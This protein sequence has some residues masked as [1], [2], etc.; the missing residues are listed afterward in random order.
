M[1]SISMETFGAS[2][3]TP[4][5]VSME[6]VR[7]ADVLLGLIGLRYGHVPTGYAK[8]VTEM[9]YEA[10]CAANKIVLMY[11]PASAF[12]QRAASADADLA[13]SLNFIT[14]IQRESHT[15]GAYQEQHDLPGI[16]AADLHRVMTGGASGIIAYRKG[17]REL[18]AANYP[19]A[20]YD[21]GW[22]V[23]LLPDDG[24]PAF[25]L[26]LAT[27]QGLRP[28]Q[29]TL[30]TVRRVQGLL[31][32]SA[33]LSPCRAVYALWGAIELDYFVNNGFGASHAARAKDLWL[34]ALA[35]ADDPYN[36]KLISWLQ[37][38]LTDDYLTAFM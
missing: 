6:R 8:S 27:L 14:R 3:L 22:A 31:E 1:V 20:L 26:A 18:E 15:C 5:H 25:L 11:V 30:D 24:A 21:L 33:R 34:Q 36:F 13:R 35:Y 9:E 29:A 37:P 4:Q 19:S 17:L 7:E 38:A 32:V 10:A 2:S 12:K 28:K 16:V 23:H